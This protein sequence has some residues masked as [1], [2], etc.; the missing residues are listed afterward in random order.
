[1]KAFVIDIDGVMTDG[2]M[3]YT[4]EGKLMKAFGPDDHEALHLLDKKMQVLFTSGD[5]RGFPISQRRVQDIGYEIV[6]TSVD[7]E[8]KKMIQDKFGLSETI[9][10][11]DG[12]YDAALFQDVG[13]SI[14]PHD[15]FYLARQAA[16]YITRSNGGERAVA[17]A[18]MHIL[19]KFCV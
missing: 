1:M 15:A 19:G 2:K 5:H 7:G 14:C 3:Y 6:L 12:I 18:C 13:Y 10:M 16:D 9:Y 11:G 17:E 4:A 8:R